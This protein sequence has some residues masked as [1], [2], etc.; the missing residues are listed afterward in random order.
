M[1]IVS[2][3]LAGL[4]CRYDGSSKPDSN[5]IRMVRRKEA[6]AVC[7]EQLGGLPT[8]RPAAEQSEGKIVTKDGKDVTSEFYDGAYKALKIALDLGCKKAILKSKSPSCGCGLIYD[9]TFTGRLITGDGIY[10][11]MLKENN[12]EVF[13]EEDY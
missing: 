13:T 8:P 11:R 4:N 6:I 3:C 2:G 9:G 7:P 5:I 10:A 1:I 12:L